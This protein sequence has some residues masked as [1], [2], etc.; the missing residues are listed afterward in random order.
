MSSTR[1]ILVLYYSRYGATEALAREICHG[2]DSIKDAAARLRTVPPVSAVTEAVENAVL[3]DG[4][5]FATR[6]DLREGYEAAGGTWSEPSFLWWKTYGTLRWGVGLAGQAAAH[7]DGS[8]PSI[9][10]AAS[11][12]RVAELEYDTLMLLRPAFEQT[13]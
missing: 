10:M 7:I 9:V 12:R 2:V 5:P 6:K 3:E 13:G 4:P 8:V 1:E 11:G